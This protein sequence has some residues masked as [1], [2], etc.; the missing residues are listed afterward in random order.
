MTS[1][2]YNELLKT[3]SD[4][5]IPSVYSNSQS[6]LEVL[7]RLKYVLEELEKDGIIDYTQN[8]QD[9]IDNIA[10]ASATATSQTAVLNTAL[11]SN[12]SELT[13]KIETEQA[14]QASAD[15][16]LKAQIDEAAKTLSNISLKRSFIIIA[17]T[18]AHLEA[19][20]TPL[21]AFGGDII[22]TAIA[23]LPGASEAL[24]E[25]TEIAEDDVTDIVYLGGTS[26]TTTAST[27]LANILAQIKM[28]Y[29]Y[30]ILRVCPFIES[31]FSD[32]AKQQMAAMRTACQQGAFYQGGAAN[33][34]AYD[35]GS[36]TGLLTALEIANGAVSY[37]LEGFIL[38]D[39]KSAQDGYFYGIRANITE[40]ACFLSSLALNDSYEKGNYTVP[41]QITADGMISYQFGSHAITGTNADLDLPEFTI[42]DKCY[43]PSYTGA[44]LTANLGTNTCTLTAKGTS[45]SFTLYEGGTGIILGG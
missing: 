42:Y 19:L 44:T 45:G 15:E 41:T 4:I 36:L 26:N 5:I 33:S 18:E 7:S 3:Y 27:D 10:E 20:K 29:L 25:L 31:P 39:I 35:N 6:Y 30:A 9:V 23:D 11:Q 13:G 38:T 24:K 32:T 28:N 34:A 43:N 16:N 8:F 2:E 40:A 37:D 21:E 17:D 14:A 22:A 1:D 12:V